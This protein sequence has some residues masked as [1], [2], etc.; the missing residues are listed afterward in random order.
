MSLWRVDDLVRT[1]R[2]DNGHRLIHG[3][4]KAS[5][6]FCCPSQKDV[7]IKLND[8]LAA[9]LE[10]VRTL[11]ESSQQ[12]EE[13]IKKVSEK[14]ATGHDHSSYLKTIDDLESQIRSA[15]QANAGL[16]LNIENTKTAADCFKEKY[17]AEL[18][19]QDTIKDDVKKLKAASTGL[20]M[21]T[22][23][24]E[25]EEQILTGELKNLMQDHKEE[26]EHLLQEKSKR[27]VNVEVDSVLPTELTGA[28]EK[29]REQYKAIANH[30]QQHYESLLVEKVWRTMLH[31][32]VL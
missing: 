25:V 7:L 6:D 30:H 13:K 21:E 20:Q 8:R 19:L 14:R 1:K 17:V 29:M 11:E 24:L 2:Q 26:R 5:A 28:L 4:R 23:C 31:L 12:L 16:W 22:R 9:Y 10:R 27:K 32:K 3:N 15:K 18:T